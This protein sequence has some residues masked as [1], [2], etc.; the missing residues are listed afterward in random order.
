MSHDYVIHYTLT[1]IAYSYFSC[2]EEKKR[3]SSGIQKFTIQNITCNIFIF[4]TKKTLG[5]R[6][7]GLNTIH[8]CTL[9]ILGKVISCDDINHKIGFLVNLL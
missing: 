1:N 6:M 8:V 2:H 3:E 9:K 4:K 5:E 7:C